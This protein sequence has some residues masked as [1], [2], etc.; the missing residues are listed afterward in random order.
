MRIDEQTGIKSYCDLRAFWNLGTTITLIS[1]L[2]QG[3]ELRLEGMYFQFPTESDGLR[4][5]NVT[6]RILRTPLSTLLRSLT[7][8]IGIQGLE[9]VGLFLSM[10]A[11]R[12]RLDPATLRLPR[13]LSGMASG[14]AGLQKIWEPQ[15]PDMEIDIPTFRIMCGTSSWSNGTLC[16]AG[17]YYE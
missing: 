17:I 11:P 16:V 12:T 10:D 4:W 5:G 6:R 15:L 13:V 7:Q 14:V 2:G 1:S 9:P 3:L 8:F